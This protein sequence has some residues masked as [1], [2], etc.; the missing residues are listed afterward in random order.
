VPTVLAGF[1]SASLPVDDST[2]AY[3]RS[4]R[5]HLRWRLER[6][7]ADL[8]ATAVV[9]ELSVCSGIARV[10]LA[11]LNGA[12]HGF[13]IK[14]ERDTLARLH[15]QSQFFSEVVDYMTLVV[16]DRFVPEATA[17][18]PQWWGVS[19]ARRRGRSV[20]FDTI[21]DCAP[22]PHVSVLPFLE[23][24]WRDEAYNLALETGVASGL[25]AASKSKLY[26]RLA[27]RVPWKVL[28]HSVLDKL[29]TRVSSSPFE[30]HTSRVALSQR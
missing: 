21:R 9:D 29:R 1:S 13:E 22:N 8:E 7:T 14:S 25:K 20:H 3:D 16:V 24:L 27:E 19:V 4:I 2:L 11:V 28:H 15:S 26:R 6:A 23:F 18:V 12:L 17:I 30:P 10:D 5:S